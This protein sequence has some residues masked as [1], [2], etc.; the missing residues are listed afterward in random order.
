VTQ[1][2]E[3][4]TGW[5]PAGLGLPCA[6][7]ARA[8]LGAMRARGRMRPM[9]AAAGGKA[10]AAPL[11]RPIRSSYQGLSARPVGDADRLVQARRQLADEVS[12]LRTTQHVPDA[13]RVR[14]LTD[15]ATRIDAL[16]AWLTGDPAAAGRLTGMTALARKLREC[17]K[18]GSPRGAGLD[19]LWEETIRLLTEF[20]AQDPPD[21]APEAPPGDVHPAADHA[22]WKRPQ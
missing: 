3:L 22:F 12:A 1:P 20:A 4:P 9:S 15:L 5:D 7:V 16:L 13:E 21:D 6:A 18:P 8:P 2:V 10:A 14:I 17:D 19:A 11:A